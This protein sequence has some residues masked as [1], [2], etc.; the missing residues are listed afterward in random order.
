MSARIPELRLVGPVAAAIDPSPSDDLL[1]LAA[2]AGDHQAF[3]ALVTRYEPAVRG[4][5]VALARNAVDGDDL[6]QEVFL[7]AWAAR[8]RYRA[9]GRFKPWL[10]TVARNLCRS[11]QRRQAIARLFVSEAWTDPATVDR[12]LAQAAS[13]SARLVRTAL[14]GLEPDVRVPL[15]LRYFA[16]LDYDDIARVIGRTPSAARSRVFYGL[17]RLAAL[18][19]EEP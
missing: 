3:A 11:R 12:E 14:A 9:E 5:C 8:R 18:V 2:A 15:V 19:G 1:M 13:P 4:F 7:R 17:R 6:A 10:F 16:G